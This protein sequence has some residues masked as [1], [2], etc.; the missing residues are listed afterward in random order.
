MSVH[1]YGSAATPELV[2]A[3]PVDR[4]EPRPRRRPASGSVTRWI[5]LTVCGIY[6]IGPLIAT[7][8]FTLQDVHGGVTLGAYKAIFN[9]PPTGQV[10]F[11]TALV[12]SLEIAVATIILTLALM[13]P[14]QLLLHLRFPRVRPFVE[15]I[16][17]LPLVFPPIV[18]VVGVE[19]TFNWVGNNKGSGL[20]SPVTWIRDQAASADPAVPVRD[21]RDAV[22]LPLGR[23]RHPRDRRPDAGRGV[24]QSRAPV[25]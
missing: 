10:G 15:V 14:T 18:L 12:Y 9:K 11:T 25:G 22:R 20:Y 21:A 6:F 13:V 5:I 7:I 23:R 2:P 19:D 24:A 17:L 4:H 16:T 8:S 3:A 1:S